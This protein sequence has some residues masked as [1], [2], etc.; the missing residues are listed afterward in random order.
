[1][2]TGSNGHTHSDGTS[3]LRHYFMDCKNIRGHIKAAACNHKLQAAAFAACRRFHLVGIFCI[4]HFV[5]CSVTLV[6]E[7]H[8]NHDF[9]A[10]R[11]SHLV[12][13]FCTKHFICGSVT[14]VW[15][16]RQISICGVSPLPPR[17]N[18]LHKAFHLRLGNVSLRKPSNWNFPVRHTLISHIHLLIW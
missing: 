11:R 5:C 13:I 6:W 8:T 17:W 10:C 16:S 1:M 14:L 4:K 9:A 18:I 12:G 3:D 15:K 7:S 2:D